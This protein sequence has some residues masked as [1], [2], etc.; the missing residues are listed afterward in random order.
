VIPIRALCH[1]NKVIQIT[2]QN[3]P[4]YVRHHNVSV[5][6][7]FLGAVDVDIVYSGMWYC[8]VDLFK[9]SQEILKNIFEFN[10]YPPPPPPS[11]STLST[12]D[13]LSYPPLSISPSNG[14]MLCRVGE[15]I[16]VACREQYP[17]THEEINYSGCDIL[18]FMENAD[19]AV[20]QRHPKN[21][22]V[23]SNGQLDWARPETWTGMLDRSPC[24]TGE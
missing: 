13:R 14:K 2:L 3:A 5:S 4:S 22:V 16:K 19:E 23:M 1:Q 18:V 7:P 17:V 9:F 8:I 10:Q 12:D 24:G 11:S 15:M 20:G 6:V 21:T